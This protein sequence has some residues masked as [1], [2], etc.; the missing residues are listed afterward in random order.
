MLAFI[1]E[2]GHPHPNDSNTWSVVVACCFSETES[3]RVARTLHALKRDVLQL[4]RMEMKGVKL[5]NRSVF[6]HRR[7]RVAFVEEFFSALLNLPVVVFAIVVERPTSLPQGGDTFLP[8]YFQ[9]LVERIELLAE[10]TDDMAT[11]LFDGNGEN[12][13]GL[14]TKFNSFIYRSAQGQ[15]YTRITDAPFFVDSKITAGIQVA[16]MVASVIRQHQQ[17]ELY[18]QTPVGDE[19]LLAIR[20]YYRIVEQKTINL[21]SPDGGDRPGI[22]WLSREHY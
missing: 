20:R 5:L 4:E 21:A 19:F 12:F 13:G 10:E 6:K 1:D 11:L 3:R 14:S 2:S 16:D 17:A 8:L 15:L 22:Y 18:K 9:Y 7:E